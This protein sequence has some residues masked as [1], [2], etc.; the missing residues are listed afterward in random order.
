MPKT[1]LRFLSKLV[2]VTQEIQANYLCMI[3]YVAKKVFLQRFFIVSYNGSAYNFLLKDG[4][5]KKFT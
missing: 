3:C 4:T 5:E 1:A 2:H